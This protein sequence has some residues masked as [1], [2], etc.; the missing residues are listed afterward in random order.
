MSIDKSLLYEVALSIVVLLFLSK[1]DIFA[2]IIDWLVQV[3][4]KL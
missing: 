4:W 3:Q 2:Q 1:S